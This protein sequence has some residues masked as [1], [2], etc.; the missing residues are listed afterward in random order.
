MKGRTTSSNPGKIVFKV[1]SCSAS[2]RP[3][4][5]AFKSAIIASRS[6][7]C[8][9]LPHNATSQSISN[10]GKPWTV[11]KLS[12]RSGFFWDWED[13]QAHTS[14]SYSEIP[15][16]VQVSCKLLDFNDV[17]W[18]AKQVFSEWK[19][20]RSE[21][22]LYEYLLA[23]AYVSSLYLQGRNIHGIYPVWLG[24]LPSNA[25]SNFSTILY[26]FVSTDFLLSPLLL[27]IFIVKPIFMCVR[28]QWPPYSTGVSARQ[29][30]GP[31]SSTRSMVRSWYQ[32]SPRRWMLTLSV[33][34]R[35]CIR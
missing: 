21:I 2:K 10:P 29:Q 33:P 1:R 9:S 28:R 23:M 27:N 32:R 19:S 16:Q 35:R 15:C 20:L 7:K 14:S 8:V 6:W 5:F 18:V 11:S 34:G 24:I 4:L 22:L 25:M 12:W 26:R 30:E 13:R 3:V 17:Q 31:L